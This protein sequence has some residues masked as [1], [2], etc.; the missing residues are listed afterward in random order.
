MWVAGHGAGH[1]LVCFHRVYNSFQSAV[2]CGACGNWNLYGPQILYVD[3]IPNTGLTIGP[4]EFW[5]FI[6]SKENMTLTG[7]LFGD[8]F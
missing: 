4:V 6:T 5:A 8:W 3:L 2:V 7:W 1:P